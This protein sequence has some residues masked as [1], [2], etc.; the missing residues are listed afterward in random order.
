MQE[1]ILENPLDCKEIKPINPKRNQPWIFIGGTNAEA[2]APLVW[3]PEAKSR[4]TGKDPRKDWRQEE[5]GM[6][7]EDMVGWNPDSM[8]IGLSKLQKMAKAREA[9]H[10]TVHGVAKSWT[11]L[12]NWTTKRKTSILQQVNKQTG[13]FRK[14]NTFSNRKSNKLRTHVMLWLNI[15]NNILEVRIL[16]HWTT[17]EVPEKLFF[18]INMSL[19]Q[20]MSS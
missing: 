12:S 17:K 19:F 16:N 20:W 14:W 10:A 5:K 6:T 7:E 3:P 18:L 11:R 2:E 15:K 13:T 4:L 1:K 9:W 8:D